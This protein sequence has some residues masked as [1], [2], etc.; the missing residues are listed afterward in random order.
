MNSSQILK[1]IF[2]ETT[3]ASSTQSLS[4]WRDCYEKITNTYINKDDFIK[5]L[6][7]NGYRQNRNNKFLIS[8][9]EPFKKYYYYNNYINDV[10]KILNE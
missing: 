3:K 10:H 9:S 1:L 7:D 6:L 8:F 4:E 2:K 5:L